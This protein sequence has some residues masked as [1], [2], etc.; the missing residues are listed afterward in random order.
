[1]CKHTYSMP[2]SK[3]KVSCEHLMKDIEDIYTAGEQYLKDCLAVIQDVRN[4]DTEAHACRVHNLRQT[5]FRNFIRSRRNASEGLEGRR[6]LEKCRNDFFDWRDRFLYELF[7]DSEIPGPDFDEAWDYVMPSLTEREVT[8]ITA[9]FKE[10]KTL[11]EIAKEKGV[12]RE[13]IREIKQ[14]ALRKLRHP[15]RSGIFMYGLEYKKLQE[16][17][18]QLEKERIAKRNE[19]LK[20]EIEAL[21]NESH[22]FPDGDTMDVVSQITIEEAGFSVRSYNSLKRAGFRTLGDVSLLRDQDMQRIR[23]IG[24]KSIRDI[25]QVLTGYSLSVRPE[26]EPISDRFIFDQYGYLRISESQRSITHRLTP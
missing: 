9:Y 13:R 18:K 26:Y 23:S 5:N 2:V 19:A 15:W 6:E 24:K 17:K 22:L 4:G 7:G 20:Q 3:L 25:I 10:E 16:E 12:T 14:K 11:E 21:S 1:M 8:V